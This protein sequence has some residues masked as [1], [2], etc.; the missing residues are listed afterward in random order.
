VLYPDAIFLRA[1]VP[2]DLITLDKRHYL[3]I[4]EMN[5]NFGGCG[6]ILSPVACRNISEKNR[7]L[8][9]EDATSRDIGQR[10]EKTMDEI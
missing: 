4:I 5:E 10:Q 6:R 8:P 9:F 7:K 2:G 3:R 1:Q